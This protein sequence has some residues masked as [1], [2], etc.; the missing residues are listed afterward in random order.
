MAP[1]DQNPDISLSSQHDNMFD[2]KTIVARRRVSFCG[3]AITYDEMSRKDYTPEEVDA[4]W[5]NLTDMRRM[6]RDANYD[7]KRLLAAAKSDRLLPGSSVSIRGLESRTKEGVK[8]RRQTRTNTYLAVFLVESHQENDFLADEFVANSYS[9]ISEPCLKAAQ[10]IGRRDE[11]EAM[12]IYKIH[13]K[14]LLEF[15]R[16]TRASQ[17]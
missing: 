13:K 11:I 15:F 14:Q 9:F 6:R 5:F 7:A 10:A 12:T 3:M 17:A 16:A 8:I 2:Q 4:S 1:L